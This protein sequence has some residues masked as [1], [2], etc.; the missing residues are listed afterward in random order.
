M[1]ASE[2]L[3]S[4]CVTQV[5]HGT[6]AVGNPRDSKTPR[7]SIGVHR[8]PNNDVKEL[9]DRARRFDEE[10]QRGRR[11]SLVGTSS[12]KAIMKE[13]EQLDSQAP[14]DD[15]NDVRKR[16]RDEWRFLSSESKAE[17]K[18]E[19]I[20]D[21]I[22]HHKRKIEDLSNELDEAS[23]AL[24]DISTKFDDAQRMAEMAPQVAAGDTEHE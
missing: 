12:W 18:V 4:T 15:F 7:I 14:D 2:M 10:M 1:R 11:A 9:Q 19:N 21:G 16:W 8:D 3:S 17:Q 20:K 23:S 5:K 22:A 24:K 6:S 13:V